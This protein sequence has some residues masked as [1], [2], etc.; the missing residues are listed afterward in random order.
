[1]GEING[2]TVE[3]YEP[4][5]ILITGGAGFIA[6]HVVLRLVKR[7]GHYKVRVTGTWNVKCIEFCFSGVC[8]TRAAEFSE[9]YLFVCRLL[10]SINLIIVPP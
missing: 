1:M 3:E 5:N 6:S 9:L 2:S 4:R 10:S 7:Y 8:N